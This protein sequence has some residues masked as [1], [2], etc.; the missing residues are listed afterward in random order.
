M[1]VVSAIFLAL[2][3]RN[4]GCLVEL[5]ELDEMVFVGACHAETCRRTLSAHIGNIDFLQFF[6]QL[7]EDA[8]GVESL[9]C[10]AVDERL[11]EEAYELVASKSE[12]YLVFE[13]FLQGLCNDDEHLVADKMSERVVDELELV[14]VEECEDARFLAQQILDEG[15][16]CCSVVETCESVVLRTHLQLVECLVLFIDHLGGEDDVSEVALSR[17]FGWMDAELDPDLVDALELE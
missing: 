13:H 8:D 17:V 15:Y 11:L 7:L 2:I 14:A 1:K 10:L 16:S 5:V 4:V 12:H 3:E 9:F 6:A